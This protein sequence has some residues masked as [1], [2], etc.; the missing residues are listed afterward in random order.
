M[1]GIP[2]RYVYGAAYFQNWVSETYGVDGLF[3][4]SQSL[5]VNTYLARTRRPGV[6]ASSLVASGLDGLRTMLERHDLRKIDVVLYTHSHADLSHAG[7]REDAAVRGV[8]L[9]RRGQRNPVG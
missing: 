4:A 9:R 7:E 1:R 3:A 6:D 2:N 8:L 5:I